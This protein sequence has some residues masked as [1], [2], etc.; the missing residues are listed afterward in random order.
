MGLAEFVQS[1]REEIANLCHRVPPT[2]HRIQIVF[3]ADT[4]RHDPIDS[5][6]LLFQLIGLR[7]KWGAKFSR[8]LAQTPFRI[9]Q[10]RL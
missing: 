6:E 8:N 4:E 5:E 3:F 9:S 2:G 10:R 1:S 7:I